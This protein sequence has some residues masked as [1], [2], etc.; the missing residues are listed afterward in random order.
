M[1]GLSELNDYNRNNYITIGDQRS[2]GA[3]FDRYAPTPQE[4]NIVS[5][6]VNVYPGIEITSIVG[7]SLAQVTYTI[8]IM[9]GVS[10]TQLTGSTLSWTNMSPDVTLTQIGNRYIITDIDTLDLWNNVSFFK[11]NLP[12]D[13]ESANIWYLKSTISYYNEETL[14]IKN[15]SWDTYDVNHY[16]QQTMYFD[17]GLMCY[18]I[19]PKVFGSNITAAASLVAYEGAGIQAFA[20]FNVNTSVYADGVVS[21][22]QYL[23]A[24]LTSN[25]SVSC[26]FIILTR[27][28]AALNIDFQGSG[29]NHIRVRDNTATL[30]AQA[31]VVCKPFATIT[32][33][34]VNRYYDG[35]KSNAI[36]ATS[37]PQI[38][39]A[40]TNATS[41]SLKLNASSG[42][43]AYDGTTVP[44][45]TAITLTS[46]TIAGLN[47]QIA[48]VRYIPVENENTTDIMYFQY[49][50]VVSGVTYS[51]QVFIKPVLLYSGTM[52]AIGSRW[53]QVNTT[54]FASIT[55]TEWMYNQ[56]D[57]ISVAGGS[58][59]GRHVAGLPGHGGGPGGVTIRN[60][61]P[62]THV[63]TGAIT[64]SDMYVEC[65][66]GVAGTGQTAGGTA[67]TAGGYTTATISSSYT[68]PTIQASPGTRG[69]DDP[70]AFAGSSG[71]YIV[72]G[73]TLDGPNTGGT[74]TN[75][76]YGNGAGGVTSNGTSGTTTTPG[77]GGN[78]LTINSIVCSKGGM[79]GSVSVQTQSTTPGSGGNAGNATVSK[80]SDGI[81]GAVF[82][83]IHP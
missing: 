21:Q 66:I 43:L 10:G 63:Y 17:A 47:S 78:G 54:G 56:M 61:I 55:Q 75:T 76:T 45:F 52:T 3:Y 11:W 6:L 48:N 16:L 37:T 30:N 26:D 23:A 5:T 65:I 38:T 50:E 82:I 13:Y 74:G 42:Y 69:D 1:I 27:F 73:T 57:I 20:H 35:N 14:Q 72:D 7:G 71:L 68:F 12:S 9:T 49:S 2:I 53:I 39:G 70:G 19:Y 67:A 59:A 44:T 46:S 40:D 51:S 79:G 28:S 15:V 62:C 24:K 80:G 25:T 4:Y 29:F 83:Y 31:T 22:V 41:Y 60:N 81:K 77:V 36:F 8:E 18:P 34:S 33:I 58:G 64:S 32:N